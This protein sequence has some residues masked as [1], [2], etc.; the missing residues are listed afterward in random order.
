[1]VILIGFVALWAGKFPCRKPDE[2]YRVTFGSASSH[3]LT[4]SY[5]VIAFRVFAR[6]AIISL[7]GH[8]GHLNY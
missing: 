2:G 6:D 3:V 7:Y 5:S 1:M 8:V 4:E